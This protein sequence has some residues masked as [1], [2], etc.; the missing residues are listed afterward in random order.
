MKYIEKNTIFNE[1]VHCINNDNYSV[2]AVTTS[3]DKQIQLSTDIGHEIIAF[4][5]KHE[6]DKAN[7][8][9]GDGIDGVEYEFSNGST[10]KVARLYE[11][12]TFDKYDSIIVDKSISL[13]MLSNKMDLLRLV[14]KV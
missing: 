3:T 7:V 2:L 9:I 10:I 4:M 12:T 8:D 11:L 6:I 1:V 14:E 13:D 5:A